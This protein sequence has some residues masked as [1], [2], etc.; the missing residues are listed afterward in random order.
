M[1]LNKGNGDWKGEFSLAG[2][3][4]PTVSEENLNV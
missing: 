1:P 3:P 2:C 4:R